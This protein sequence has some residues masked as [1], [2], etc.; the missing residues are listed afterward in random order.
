MDKLKLNSALAVC[1]NTKVSSDQRENLIHE[2]RVLLLECM[3]RS[4][5]R[6]LINAGRQSED[7]GSLFKTNGDYAAAAKKWSDDMLYF[8]AKIVRDQDG[9]VTDRNDRSTFTGIG[10]AKDNR[11][12]HIL[13]V[14]MNEIM[15]PVTPYLISEI[16]GEMCSVV[17]VDPGKTYTAAINSNAVIQWEDATWTSLRS[18]PQDRLYAATITLNPKPFG[19]RASI[20]WYQM[21][22][23]G[24]NLVDTMAAMAGGYAA[25]VMQKFT[26]AFTAA[27]AQTKY[28]PSS[29][30]ATGYTGNNWATICQK[31]AMA[32]RVRRDQLIAYGDF[33]ALRKVLP[34]NASLAS[35]IMMQLGEEY[36]KNGYLM[37]HDGVLLYEIHPVADPKTINT[38]LTSVWPTDEIIV[39]ARASDRYAPMLMAWE[40][41]LEMGS[42]ELTAGDDIMATGRIEVLQ[43]ASADIAPCFASRVGIISEIT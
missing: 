8:C 9:R 21:V 13:S 31:V 10:M 24:G 29:L 27:A 32:N 23:N 33:L 43:Y 25:K 7:F 28:V 15:Y 26:D 34:D 12:L 38:T 30:K 20:N 4:K 11:F 35:A 40:N 5:N 17:T 1:A 42:V 2:G 16:V 19:A 22:G 6:A 39:A 14:A 3:G 18:V 41:N 36:F 37:S